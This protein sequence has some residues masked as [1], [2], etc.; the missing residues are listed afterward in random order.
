MRR[1]LLD[2]TAEDQVSPEL[3]RHDGYVF[4]RVFVRERRQ[5]LLQSCDRLGRMPF[6]VVDLGEAGGDSPGLVAHAFTLERR[7]G[8]L[9]QSPRFRAPAPPPGHAAGAVLQVGGGESV[10]GEL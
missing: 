2:S 1:G 6:A 4:V 9:E 8:V 3:S 10:V 7:V 5:G